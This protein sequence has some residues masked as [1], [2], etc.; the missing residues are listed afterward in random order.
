MCGLVGMYTSRKGGLLLSDASEFFHLLLL[1]SVRGAHSTG[2][3]GVDMRYLEQTPDIVKVFGNPYNL[4]NFEDFDTFNK[5]IVADYT[6]VLGHGRYAT[7]GAV[8]AVNAHPFREDHIT[9][10]H[11]GGISNFKNLQKEK[12]LE[13]IEVDSH[14]VCKM[15]ATEGVEKAMSQI[16]GMY[17]FMW[18]D[19]QKSTFNVLRNYARPLFY[20]KYQNNDTLVF[21]SERETLE[22]N[23]KRNKT[24][25][26]EIVEVPVN[27]MLTWDG[28]SLEPERKVVEG[29]KYTPAH[30][31][32]GG[33]ALLPNPA[34]GRSKTYYIQ[35]AEDGD[36]RIE[37]GQR[38]SVDLLDYIPIE[39]HGYVS[40]E[41]V[42]GI[43]SH[44]EFIFKGRKYNISESDLIS[45]DGISGE[46]S[47]MTHTIVAGVTTYN[48]VLINIELLKAVGDN[49]ENYLTIKDAMDDT[50]KRIS[51][52]R[53]MEIAENPCGWCQDKIDAKELRENPDA[54]GIW[55][56]SIICPHC[57][58]ESRKKPEAGCN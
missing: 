13:R 38:I 35:S 54:F 22:W 29:K 45:C 1:N 53:A 43:D 26:S 49:D 18:Y 4:F 57:V 27:T 21:A 41:L 12:G 5:R 28:L 56:D 58:S 16:D 23:A 6:L 51:K 52:W 19:S 32:T 9:L 44:P 46:V 20:G 14:L 25:L 33:T 42:G 3:A 34:G 11:N 36:F 50:P 55:N 8:N 40:Y 10:V 31:T 37:R 48:V 7:Q 17:A 47:A 2:V 24:P 30:S 39:S 15:F